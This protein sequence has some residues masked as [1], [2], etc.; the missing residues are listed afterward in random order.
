MALGTQGR[1][2][3]EQIFGLGAR[4]RPPPPPYTRVTMCEWVLSPRSSRS[5]RLPA[6]HPL[7]LQGQFRIPD[8]L[9]TLPPEVD[10]IF[11]EKRMSARGLENSSG[12]EEI[13]LCSQRA[14]R[15]SGAVF[16]IE[17]TKLHSRAQCSVAQRFAS[18]HRLVVRTSRYG[19]DNPGSTPGEDIS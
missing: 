8:L 6:T 17:T 13:E 19:R 3:K 1:L 11:G 12:G 16:E 2:R 4:A 5:S 7:G 15:Q 10:G 9:Q 14:L 18:P